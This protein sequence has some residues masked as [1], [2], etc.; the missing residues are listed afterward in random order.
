MLL[1]WSEVKTTGGMV[2]GAFQSGAR[3]F[4][5]IPYAALPLA[6]LRLAAP[7]PHP[8][9]PDTRLATAFGYGCPQTPSDLGKVLPAG[10][11]GKF[12]D[13]EDCL[14]LNV[15]TPWPA[16]GK[17][18]PVLV[19]IHGGG[20]TSGGSSVAHIAPAGLTLAQRH[21]LVVVSMNY[22]LGPLGFLAHPALGKSSGNYGIQDQQ[23]ALRWVQ[24]NIGAFGGDPQNV[25]LAG[26]SAGA[27]SVCVHLTSPGSK[28]LFHRAVMQSGACPQKFPQNST[29]KPR[30]EAEAQGAKLAA[31]VGCGASAGAAACL[32]GKSYKVL[33]SALPVSDALTA[34]DGGVSWG[35][36]IDGVT[37]A[38]QP[39]DLVRA[40][41]FNKVPVLLGTNQD[42]GTLLV[43]AA[44]LSTLS[45]T[46]Y[47]QFLDKMFGMGAMFIKGRYAASKYQTP[48]HALAD[49]MSDLVFVCTAR[50]SARALAAA[51][52]KTYLYNFTTS[53]GYA[54]SNP[55]LGAYHGAEIPFVFG[56]PP[57][58]LSFTGAEAGLSVRMMAYWARFAL[59][60]DP[61]GGGAPAW[62]AYLKSSD[63]H[64]NLGDKVSA[65][66]G[67]KQAAC[68]FWDTMTP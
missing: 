55:F 7:K 64:L 16:P 68:D 59:A 60:G 1:N 32:R 35:P 4:L 46:A 30:A 56:A 49:L 13:S 3:S 51:G 14:T 19:W 62:P 12:I 39:L 18:A 21:G 65:A 63:G 52:I 57:P 50:R 34:T 26:E 67:L 9:W 6:A 37:L 48:G 23:L 2:R 28:G 27:F 36:N 61:N 58:G 8:G 54:K 29:V 40:K 33:L 25:T 41:T 66:T 15:W 5:G 43:A 11:P 47:T 20:Y 22:R 45:A 44:G 31:K 17:A 10:T 38:K 24:Q 53:P 42:E